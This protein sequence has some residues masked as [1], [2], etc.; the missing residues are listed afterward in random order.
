MTNL[1][2]YSDF[3]DQTPVAG[4][5][6]RLAQALETAERLAL[7]AEC[8]GFSV[9]ELL[10]D[11]KEIAEYPATRGNASFDAALDAVTWAR[12]AIENVAGKLEALTVHLKD[13]VAA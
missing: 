7:D 5:K 3:P 13:A 10:T 4:V 6:D 11:L 1:H 2:V 8:L 12:H 9:G